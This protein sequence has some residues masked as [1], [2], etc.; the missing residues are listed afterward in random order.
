MH[1]QLAARLGSQL[2][3]CG[4]EISGE[5]GRI[6][7]CGAVSLVDATYLGFVFNAVQIG[8]APGTAHVPQEPAKTS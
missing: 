4:P 5:N 7:P 3:D 6:R 8:L 2:A 1:L